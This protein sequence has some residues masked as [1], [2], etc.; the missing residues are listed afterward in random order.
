MKGTEAKWFTKTLKYIHTVSN[1]LEWVGLA[2]LAFMVVAAVVD[3]VGAKLFKSPLSGSTEITGLLQIVAIGSGLAFSKIAGQQIYV[4][5]LI[6]S[7]KGRLKSALEIIRSVLSL[8]LWAV[9][10]W[11]VFEYALKLMKRG[12]ETFLL[13]IPLYPFAF[14]VSICCCV[15][16]C[17][18]LILDLLHPIVVRRKTGG[19]AD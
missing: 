11:M 12:T 7:A 14:W 10:A 8:L 15:P 17:L 2:F 18:L 19:D 3:V 4:G 5:F 6:D 16:M 9:A 1:V 13:G